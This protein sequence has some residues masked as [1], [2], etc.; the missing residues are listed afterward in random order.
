MMPFRRGSCGHYILAS[1]DAAGYD[2]ETGEAV[3]L[4]AECRARARSHQPS[5]M[6]TKGGGSLT[7]LA[8]SLTVQAPRGSTT[9]PFPTPAEM[10]G[11]ST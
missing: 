8:P 4:C 5:S 6:E 9:G 3:Y 2:A 1:T 10:H 11:G 7:V